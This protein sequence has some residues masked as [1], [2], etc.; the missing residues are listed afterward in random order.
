MSGVGQVWTQL[1]AKSG[2]WRHHQSADF[3]FLF[4][5]VN[6]KVTLIK[7]QDFGGMSDLQISGTVP[8]QEPDI[9]MTLAKAWGF[10]SANHQV[11]VS[12]CTALCLCPHEQ[13]KDSHLTSLWHQNIDN[14]WPK[15]LHQG[16]GLIV[17][18]PCYKKILCILC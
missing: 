5:P 1:A 2:L 12:I 11:V 18:N 13:R 8:L 15:G 14:G 7:A 17:S 3:Q 16:C 4:S 10:A 9:T 6:L